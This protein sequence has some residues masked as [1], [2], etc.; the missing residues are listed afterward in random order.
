M[1]IRCGSPVRQMMSAKFSS[2]QTLK[3]LDLLRTAF[4]PRSFW[5]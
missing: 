1:Y 2:M 5:A 4:L 3:I